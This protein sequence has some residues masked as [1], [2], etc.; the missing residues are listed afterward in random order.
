[1]AKITA[2]FTKDTRDAGYLSPDEIRQGLRDGM[3]YLAGEFE[4]DV[5]PVYNEEKDRMEYDAMLDAAFRHTQN[6]LHPNPVLRYEGGNP[7]YGPAVWNGEF[8][9]RSSMVGDLFVVDDGLVFEV[10]RNFDFNRISGSFRLLKKHG[11]A[12]LIA[13]PWAPG[14]EYETAEERRPLNTEFDELLTD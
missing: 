7:V 11:R 13:N 2:L 10:G 4:V 3:F 5:E 9:Q 14:G 12:N 8:A 1:M 6:D